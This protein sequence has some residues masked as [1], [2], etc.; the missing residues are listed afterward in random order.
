MPP[1][2]FLEINGSVQNTVVC[3]HDL[4]FTGV[5]LSA[6]NHLRKKCGSSRILEKSIPVKG[7]ET[8]DLIS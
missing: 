5:A 3:E 2:L 6:V 1:Y 7:L 8:L 4:S